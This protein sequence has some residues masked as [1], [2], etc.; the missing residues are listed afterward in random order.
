ME[1]IDTVITAVVFFAAGGF[2]QAK[3]KWPWR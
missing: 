3:K 1:W 2:V